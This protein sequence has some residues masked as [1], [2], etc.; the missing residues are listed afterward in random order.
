MR[1]A[2]ILTALA[3]SG[4]AYAQAACAQTAP[5]GWKVDASADAWLATSPDQKV[6]LAFYPAVKNASAFV[7]WFQDEGLR[8]TSAYSRTIIN[9]DEPETATDPKVG[10]LLGQ[11]RMLNISGAALAV[12]SYGWQTGKGKQL[13]QI[14][15]PAT[16]KDSPAYKAALEEITAAWKAGVAYTPAG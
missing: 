15:L 8:R 10:P 11:A 9:Q 12:Q 5:K 16:A 3:L 1:I 4:A 14:I 7:F 2:S 13:V 6:R